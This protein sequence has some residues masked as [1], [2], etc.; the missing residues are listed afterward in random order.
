M[1]IMT[2][3]ICVLIGIIIGS[4]FFGD[5]PYAIGA[6]NINSFFKFSAGEYSDGY[7]IVR[8]KIELQDNR[9]IDYLINN[10]QI[11]DQEKIWVYCVKK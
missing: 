4:I 11:I 8:A 1:K 2:Q 3:A 5:G 7:K 9:K 10:V 6:D